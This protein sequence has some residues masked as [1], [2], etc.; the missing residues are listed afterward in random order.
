[1]TFK[2]YKE[3]V[4]NDPRSEKLD[5]NP[6]GRNHY[7]YRVSR[8]EH[9]YGSKSEK[10]GGVNDTIGDGYYTSSNYLE[11]SFKGNPEDYKVKIIRRFDNPVDKILFE[12]YLHQKFDVKNHDSFINRSNQTPWGFDTTGTAC[13]S[14][15][16]RAKSVYQLNKDTGKIIREWDC[17]ATAGRSTKISSSGIQACLSGLYLSAGNYAWCRPEFYSKETISQIQKRNYNKK[18][19]NNPGS[20]EVYQLDKYNGKIIKKWSCVTAAYLFF[21]V[22]SGS[23]GECANGNYPSSLGYIWCW[24]ENYSEELII[25]I[26]NKNWDKNKG[27]H[28]NAIPI[29][30][31]DK[32]SRNIIKRWSCTTEAQ[33]YMGSGDINACLNGRTQTA[34]GYRWVKD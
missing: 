17:I 16:K 18:L 9:Y 4:L 30:Q 25:K 33:E 20:K 15:N 7:V 24:P 13:G 10:L 12:S 19:E 3:R 31:L 11:E 22:N 23:I 1:M 6:D 2:K 8:E 26:Q 21:G 28:P 5:F 14:N 34:C 27:N 29:L 32:I